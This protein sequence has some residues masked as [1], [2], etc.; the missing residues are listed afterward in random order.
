MRQWLIRIWLI[1]IGAM[2]AL[3]A[4]EL[5]F[6][7][8]PVSAGLYR[9]EQNERWP[10]QNYE[11]RLD[12][13]YSQGWDLRNP[14]HGTTNNY[15]HPSPFDY[16]PAS[17]PVVIIGDS[18]IESLM[19]DY[20]DTLQGQLGGLLGQRQSVYGLGASG[21]SVS[22]YLA[23]AAQAKRE[24]APRAAVFLIVDGDISE[25]LS[26]RIG[27]YHFVSR[28][29]RL[30]L[31]YVPFPAGALSKRI[32]KRIGEISL[33][34]YLRA[35]LQFEPAQIFAPQAVAGSSSRVVR[36]ETLQRRAVD[37]FLG[38][39]PGEAGIA[40]NCIVFLMD[41][42]RYAIYSAKAATAPKDAPATRAYFIEQARASGFQVSDLG[43][44][45]S[46]GHRMDGRRYD[47]WPN[48]RHWNRAGHGLGAAEAYRLLFSP[49]LGSCVSAAQGPR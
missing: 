42:D 45:F 10:L 8:L 35:N 29:G 2:L 5:L 24:F 20:P 4:L 39:L 11:S 7:L 37:H 38:H 25:S 14:H 12:Y 9:S 36:D 30:Q 18:F 33:W 48:D 26:S 13:T 3:L 40:P 1:G 49:G 43:P 28:D 44:L 17:N 27:N 31:D 21:L 34:R 46:E 16:L 47:Y 15:G 23:L 22:D 32:Q 41:A 6:R 19:N